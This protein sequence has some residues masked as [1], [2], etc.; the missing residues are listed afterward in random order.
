VQT[1]EGYG[2]RLNVRFELDAPASDLRILVDEQR[3]LQVLANLLSNAAK[4]SPTHGTVQVTVEPSQHQARICVIDC[5]PGIPEDFRERIF[6]RFCQADSSSTRSAG[7][8]GLGLH[9][10]RQIVERMGGR[11][12]FDTEIGKGTTFWVEFPRAIA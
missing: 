1:A 9:I 3:L 7:G 6:G 5:G 10:S 11:I 2:Q 4:F 8:T 12:G